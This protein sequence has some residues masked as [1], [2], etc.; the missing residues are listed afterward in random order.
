MSIL[1]VMCLHSVV[2][3]LDDIIGKLVE[4]DRSPL[5]VSQGKDYVRIKGYWNVSKQKDRLSV[6]GRV[7]SEAG[8][9]YN[10]MVLGKLFDDVSKGS[11]F[12]VTKRPCSVR[13]TIA[14]RFH[15]HTLELTF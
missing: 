4:R 2:A 10:A 14:A 11:G 1:M 5:R 8:S 13:N 12:S 7:G 9:K 3:S 15:I 6:F